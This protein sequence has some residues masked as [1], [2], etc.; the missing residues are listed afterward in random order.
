MKRLA[1]AKEKSPLKV[2]NGPPERGLPLDLSIGNQI[3]V[4]HRAIQRLLQAKIGP[5]GATL[6]MWY[7]LRALWDE[8]GLTQAELSRRIGTMEPTALSAIHSM[9]RSGLVR[10]VRNEGDKRKVNIFLTEKGRN[11]QKRLLP[12]G[13]SV[14]DTALRGFTER[15]LRFLLQLLSQ[16]QVNLVDEMKKT[17]LD[18]GDD[19]AEL[20]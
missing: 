14:V 10:R 16:I 3:R 20:L 19:E 17:K 12:L 13:I 9:E 6:G 7:F 15:E 8:D 5:Y 4:T 18:I 11:L 2:S 1:E